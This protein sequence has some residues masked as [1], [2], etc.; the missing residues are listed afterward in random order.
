MKAFF[1]TSGPSPSG[2]NLVLNEIVELCRFNG[3]DAF[4][5]MPDDIVAPLEF[6]SNPAPVVSFNYLRQNLTNDDF[7]VVGWHTVEERDFL[8][9]SKARLKIFWQHGILLPLG[10]GLTGEDI[11]RD[12]AFDQYWNVSKA[13]GEFICEKYRVERY[14]LVQP[15]FSDGRQEF[16][17]VER[18]Y[19][20]N[21]LVVLAQ[22]RRGLEQKNSLDKIARAGGVEI[23]MLRSP[24]SNTD[25]IN[26]LRQADIFL[27]WDRGLELPSIRKRYWSYKEALDGKLPLTD[28]LFPPKK[29]VDHGV[30]LLGFPI[31]AAQAAIAG[32]CVV[33]YPM[34]GGLE[35]MDSSN[36]YL[37]NDGDA[38]SFQSAFRRAIEDDPKSRKLRAEKAFRRVVEFSSTRTW[39]KIAGA[40]GLT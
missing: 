33:A 10:P 2:G 6:V 23:S 27:S 3:L 26:A 34:G 4:L 14:E 5:A 1:T 35:W 29:W 18:A 21:Q 11:L 16:S 15:F 31:G 39:S 36:T 22:E 17:D 32:A 24:F 20:G 12:Q 30:Q 7:L 38:R 25:F 13:C 9:Y 40:F 19:S 8:R 37:A 28:A